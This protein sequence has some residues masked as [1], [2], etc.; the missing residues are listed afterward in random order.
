M[1]QA[2]I[3]A[4]PEVDSG[5]LLF[6]RCLRCGESLRAIRDDPQCCPGCGLAHRRRPRTCI[7]CGYDLRGLDGDVLRCPECFTEQTLG[8]IDRRHVERFA[9]AHLVITM[10]AAAAAALFVALLADVV[11]WLAWPAAGF[12]W[13]PVAPL[14]ASALALTL[15]AFAQRSYR[16]PRGWLIFWKIQ[17]FA[18]PA[19]LLNEIV[20]VIGTLL[21]VSTVFVPCIFSVAFLSTA[22]IVFTSL[23]P[24]RALLRRAHEAARPIAIAV[25]QAELTR[26]R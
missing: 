11:L 7:R 16:A 19:M 26:R 1:A 17:V 15:A 12:V 10:L 4:M 20:L 23:N 8:E 5:G 18:L 3:R 14:L 21:S 22:A 9:R 2:I 24:T 25:E 13:R 6:D